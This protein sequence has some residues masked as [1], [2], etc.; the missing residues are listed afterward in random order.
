MLGL[1]RK[2]E[3]PISGLERDGQMRSEWASDEDM[4]LLLA[5]LMPPNR[6]AIEV[7]MQT[8]L[9]IGDVLAITREQAAK[10]RW[11]VTEAK[12]GK[13]RRVRVTLEQQ[14][15][16][17]SQAGQIYV[18]PNRLD[19]KRH[20]TRQAV[21][22]DVV[23]AAKAFRLTAHITP[24]SAR[25]IYAV[26]RYDRTGDISEVQRDLGHDREATTLV[27]ALAREMTERRHKSPRRGVSNGVKA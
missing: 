24:H 5:A 16:M 10:G 21:Y 22:K 3:F 23:R 12:T 7:S 19:G 17:L 6:L 1:P 14:R 4:Q 18:W 15:R 26:K 20:R 8:G 11:T 27:Y 2:F 9:R 25:K 13:H